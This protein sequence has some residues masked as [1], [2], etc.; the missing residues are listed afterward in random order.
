MKKQLIR[1]AAVIAMLPVLLMSTGCSLSENYLKNDRETNQ[2]FQDLRDSLAPREIP[3]ANSETSFGDV[4]EFQ[5][6]A[7]DKADNLKAMPMVTISVNEGVPLKDV[8]Y[9][10]AQQANYDIELDPRI[11]GAV[12]F[13]ARNRPFD[14]VMERICEM[15]GLRYKLDDNRV[16]VELDT[17]YTETY[18][19]DYLLMTRKV[20]SQVQNN[21]TVS[22]GENAS[23][24]STFSLSGTSDIDFWKELDDNIKQIIESNST[25]NTLRTANTPTVISAPPAGSTNPP[26]AP[27][28]QIT[29]GVP[30]A[31]VASGQPPSPPMVEGE[32]SG[33]ALPEFKMSYSINKQAG[34]ISV[35]ATEKI[36]KKIKTYLTDLRKA[37]TAQ[38]LIEAK[39]FEVNLTDEY[40]AG[41]NWGDL[42][43]GNFSL[44]YQSS[45]SASPIPGLSPASDASMMFTF[46]GGDFSSVVQAVSRFGTVH[47]L[48][49]PRLTVLNNQTAVLNVAKNQTYFEVDVETTTPDN[50]APVTTVDSTAK[51]VPEGILVNVTP[52]IDSDHGEVTMTVRPT[53]TRIDDFVTDP[54]VAFAIAQIGSSLTPAQLASLQS[55]VP[56][57]SVQE[58]DSV[59][60]MKSGEVAILGGL[61]QDRAQSTQNGAPVLS[62]VP[63][64]G[65]LFRNQ[66]DKITKTEIV[67]FLRATIVDGASQAIHQTDR[68]L[69]RTYSRDR[70][71]FP[72]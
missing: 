13:S 71:P 57:V 45:A 69:Y 1:S 55:Q 40:A 3:A 62:E 51:S 67:V 70:R 54:G 46:S 7:V 38:V 17:P 41:I 25:D 50:G 49:S 72:L 34:L 29:P 32:S 47:A 24:G 20:T 16:R 58:F 65:G 48:A 42:V 59:I 2:E 8:L 44:G 35:F 22:G 28:S 64:L 6:Y 31:V 33:E 39:V 18:K 15:A 21:A 52:S 5:D 63:L 60:R 12:I 36:Q 11:N 43:K 26:G 4:P 27:G 9:E 37:V 61:L 10:L 14:Q 68:D 66:G 56:N 30:P 23:T 53:I 19:I